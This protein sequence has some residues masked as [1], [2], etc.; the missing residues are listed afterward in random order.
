MCVPDAPAGSPF[1]EVASRQPGKDSM[2]RPVSDRIS[3][4]T[5]EDLLRALCRDGWFAHDQRGNHVQL[6]YPVKSGRVTVPQHAGVTLK[7]KSLTQGARSGRGDRR[8][9]V[10]ISSEC[11]SRSPLSYAA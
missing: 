8:P 10:S 2:F 4:I 7:R 3:R 5:A 9:M 11:A 1:L 6:R